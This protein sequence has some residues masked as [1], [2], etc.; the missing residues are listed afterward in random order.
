MINK[1]KTYSTQCNDC[2]CKEGELHMMGCDQE[3]CTVC[4][5]QAITCMTGNPCC[6]WNKNKPGKCKNAIPEPYFDH[7]NICARCG[8]I[9]PNFQMVSEKEWKFICGVTYSLNSVLCPK[10]MNY[11]KQIRMVN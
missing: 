7:P 1:K 2:G 10:C 9:D 5:K 11:I 8:S 3:Y 6:D 4:G